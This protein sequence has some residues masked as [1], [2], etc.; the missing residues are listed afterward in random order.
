MNPRMTAL[1][2]LFLV[3][4]SIVLV[5]V[6]LRF[7]SEPASYAPSRPRAAQ[8]RPS[9]PEPAAAPS[10][11]QAGSPGT[12]PVPDRPSWGNVAVFSRSREGRFLGPEATRGARAGNALGDEAALAAMGGPKSPGS[13]RA[14]GE[15]RGLLSRLAG[16][17][18]RH[19]AA[20]RAL[21]NNRHVVDGFMSRD[22]VQRNC[23]SPQALKSYLLDGR[24][25]GGVQEVL[26]KVRS[27]LREPDAARA[28]AGTRFAQAL[29]QCPSLQALSQDAGSIQQIL[30]ANPAYLGILTDPAFA[31]G[32]GADAR[33]L[34]VFKNVNAAMSS[35]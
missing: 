34:T 17:L 26:P 14:L 16:E 27:F 5:A 15:R 23:S 8:P 19:P 30:A 22:L 24:S 25:P 12:A 29:G 9:R 20:L 4:V 1:A 32:L 3:F 11:T 28:V 35:P 2:V 31:N 18:L 13:A 21:F 7:G 6:S 10:S 33:A